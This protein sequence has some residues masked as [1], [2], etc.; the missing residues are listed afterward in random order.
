MEELF[1]IFRQG[2]EQS[3]YYRFLAIFL[4]IALVAVVSYI[5]YRIAIITLKIGVVGLS[6]YLILSLTTLKN[7]D[8]S[9]LTHKIDVN[10]IKKQINSL[11][12][13][14]SNLAVP[15]FNEIL[16]NE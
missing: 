11:L 3:E 1:S 2:L 9:S 16:N 13:G 5:I 14:P 4:G 12:K 6:I 7:E 8:E 10:T 15:L